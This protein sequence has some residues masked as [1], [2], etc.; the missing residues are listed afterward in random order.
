M[1]SLTTVAREGGGDRVVAL[2]D[3]ADAPGIRF[4]ATSTATDLAAGCRVE[5]VPGRPSGDGV[6]PLPLVRAVSP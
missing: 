5:L 6:D 4:L 2:V 3:A 1:W